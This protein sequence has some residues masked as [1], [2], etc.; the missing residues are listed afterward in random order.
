M[1]A[2]SG[3]IPGRATLVMQKFQLKLL[4]DAVFVVTDIHQMAAGSRPICDRFGVLASCDRQLDRRHLV[5]GR[6]RGALKPS[7]TLRAQNLS[8]SSVL[9]LWVLTNA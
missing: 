6:R 1:R 2:Q 4:A 3:D 7:R 5:G 8:Q 9:L